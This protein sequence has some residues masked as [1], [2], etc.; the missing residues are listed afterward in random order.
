[1]HVKWKKAAS[2][3]G[4]LTGDR[5]IEADVVHG[6]ASPRLF[7]WDLNSSWGR[8]GLHTWDQMKTFNGSPVQT[9]GDFVG[10]RDSTRV[11]ETVMLGVNRDGVDRRVEV[12]IEPYE[13]P[14][15]IISR[16]QRPTARQNAVF[17]RWVEGK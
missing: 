1:M 15:V 7:L 10:F 5:R 8:A 6:E 13:W 4:T 16:V 11:G 12:K 3:E 2:P 17:D 9:Y 14:R